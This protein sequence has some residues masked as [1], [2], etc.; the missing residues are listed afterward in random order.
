MYSTSPIKKIVGSFT[1]D[2]IIEDEPIKLWRKCNDSSGVSESTFF[3]YFH[4]KR[5]GYAIKIKDVE[6]FQPINPYYIIPNFSPPQSF[7]YLE[8]DLHCSGV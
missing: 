7:C 3:N 1:I 8:N 6:Y 5:I 4:N 2:A